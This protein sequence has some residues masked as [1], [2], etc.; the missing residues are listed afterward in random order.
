[1]NRAERVTSASTAGSPAWTGKLFLRRNILYGELARFVYQVHENNVLVNHYEISKIL[2]APIN[3]GV[4]GPGDTSCFDRYETEEE[5]AEKGTPDGEC[6]EDPFV[7]FDLQEMG[8]EAPSPTNKPGVSQ[9]LQPVERPEVT[10]VARNTDGLVRAASL[11]HTDAQA[12]HPHG[13]LYA[14]RHANDRRRQ[15]E[16]DADRLAQIRDTERLLTAFGNEAHST[17]A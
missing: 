3:P 14:R 5:L 11:T 6:E 12:V 16:F 1:M 4:S 13:H 7:D 9:P 17:N 10:R 8:S 15:S 2:K